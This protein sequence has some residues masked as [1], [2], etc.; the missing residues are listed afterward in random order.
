MIGIS[1]KVD[2]WAGAD[3]YV[4]AHGERWRAV[5]NESLGP[6]EDVMVVGREGLTLKVA[7][8]A[9]PGGDGDRS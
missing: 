9:A 5:S 8:N 1:G 7:R 6:G 4:I 2:S 3:G